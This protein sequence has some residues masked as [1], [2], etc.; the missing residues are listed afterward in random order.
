LETIA[1]KI[2]SVS[3]TWYES[4]EWLLRQSTRY[5]TEH[6]TRT[7]VSI[8]ARQA[9]SSFRPRLKRLSKIEQSIEE[10]LKRQAKRYNKQY[11][12]EMVHITTRTSKRLRS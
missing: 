8:R 7:T 10:K 1:S 3:V 6:E 5:S 11:L 4:T 2:M 9:L 12:G